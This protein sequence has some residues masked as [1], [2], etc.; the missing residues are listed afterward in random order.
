MNVLVVHNFYQQAGGE[1]QVFADEIALLESH[2]H[3]VF[4][5]TVHNDQISGL[6]KITVAKKTI[7]N[8]EAAAAIRESVH[9][10]SIEV[11]H[12]HN[13]FPLLSPAVYSAAHRGGAAVVQTIH[14]YRLICPAA[15]FLRDGH[16]CE[17]C[18]GKTFPAPAVKY[19]C[20]R[21]SKSA[22]AVAATMLATHKTRGTYRD[23]VDAYIALTQFARSKFI[24]AD[25]IPEAK[26][27]VKPNLVS[28]DP[29][30]GAGEGGYAIFVGR[31]TESKGILTLLAAWEKLKAP[32]AL[33]IL[34][35]GELAEKVKAAAAND[36]RIEYLGRQPLA[37]V[38]EAMGQASALVFPSVWYE[39]MPKTIIESFAKG[40]PV[41]ASRLGSMT[42]M[43]SPGETGALFEA[44]AAGDLAAT[45]EQLFANREKLVAM[46][47]TSRR[48]FE[49]NYSADRN[50]TQLMHIYE[51]AIANKQSSTV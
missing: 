20:Y 8:D 26:L 10:N 37:K 11:A 48:E 46:R 1:D 34:G 13:T 41:I 47:A 39:G 33:K 6:S 50:Y 14:N 25:F 4:K 18:L 31:L 3:R 9:A 23:D 16:V 36:P 38:Y 30:F 2:G 24:E 29:G 7:W 44:G 21:G 5:H 32:V 45:I 19:N 51:T 43:I 17:L 35:D 28:P 49:M 27:H 42:E 22:T 40:T 15:T 12:F